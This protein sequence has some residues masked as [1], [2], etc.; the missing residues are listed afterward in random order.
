MSVTVGDP[1]VQMSTDA[2]EVPGY[3]TGPNLPDGVR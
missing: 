3:V 2:N 1:I